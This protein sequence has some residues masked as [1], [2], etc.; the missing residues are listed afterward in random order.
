MGF[1]R[2]LPANP[3][4]NTSQLHHKILNIFNSMDLHFHH[5]SF[6]RPMPSRPPQAS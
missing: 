3:P 1:E 4:G 6:F 5:I 2:A